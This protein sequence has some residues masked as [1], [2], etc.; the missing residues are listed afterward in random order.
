MPQSFEDFM[1]ERDRISAA[2]SSGDADSLDTI[3]ATTG[4]ATFFPPPGGTVSG[5][6]NVRQRYRKDASAFSAGAK[7]R[8]DILDSG[9][10]GELAFWTGVQHFE[11][12]LQG[13]DV[14]LKLR[15]TEIFRLEDGGWKLV[16]RHADPAADPPA[17]PDQG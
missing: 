5:A 1:A 12:R 14:R 8:L 4:A 3:V 13:R 17:P 16:H 2:Y 7:N 15:V 6:E 10:S 11:G 9:A